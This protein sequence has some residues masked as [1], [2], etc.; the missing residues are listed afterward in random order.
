MIIEDSFEQRS[1]AWREAKAG[2]PGASS[3][4]KIVTSKGAPSKQAKDYIYQLA[5]EKILGRIEETYT[6]FAMQQGIDREDEARRLYELITG[7]QVHQVALVYKNESKTVSCSP[8]GLLDAERL[9]DQKGLEIKCPMLKTHVKYLLDNTT[10]TK[11][12]FIQV[13]GSM[14]VCGFGQYDLMSYVPGMPPIILT[15]ERDHDFTANLEYEMSNFIREL[16]S[17]YAKLKEKVG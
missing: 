4:N 6:S 9:E 17:V 15:I 14:F 5:G 11:E 8:D 1:D 3:F 16:K 10:L 12:Y 2:I 13:Q 7:K